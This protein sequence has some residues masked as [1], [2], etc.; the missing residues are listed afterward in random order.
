[1]AGGC[2]LH[3]AGERESL[4]MNVYPKRPLG[5]KRPIISRTRFLGTI[6]FPAR[7]QHRARCAPKSSSGCVNLARARD[8]LASLEDASQP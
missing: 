6:A 3:R 4:T 7:R 2:S 1:M 5:C 8:A